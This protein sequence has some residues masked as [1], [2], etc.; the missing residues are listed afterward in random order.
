MFD[1]CVARDKFDDEDDEPSLLQG[2]PVVPQGQN[3]RL[4]IEEAR[5]SVPGVRRDKS[6]LFTRMR[7][8]QGRRRFEK[9]CSDIAEHA[10]SV[11]L[12]MIYAQVS[13]FHTS[14]ASQ[15]AQYSGLVRFSKDHCKSR[16]P[17]LEFVSAIPELTNSINE[18]FDKLEELLKETRD[19]GH[20]DDCP[21]DFATV[22]SALERHIDITRSRLRERFDKESETMLELKSSPFF[23]P[24]LTQKLGPK[25]AQMRERASSGSASPTTTPS[26]SLATSPNTTPCPPFRLPSAAAMASS[27]SDLRL[28]S[29]DGMLSDLESEDSD[30]D[31]A[32]GAKS[33]CPRVLPEGSAGGMASYK[34]D[35][36]KSNTSRIP[37]KGALGL[38]SLAGAQLQNNTRTSTPC[39]TAAKNS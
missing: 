34:D 27:V 30:D 22:R 5:L 11:K 13:E 29:L 32:T 2:E 4:P 31:A 8:L 38:S 17:P 9:P 24:K 1:V 10:G 7:E 20:G 36:A 25:L 3:P 15:L 18:R 28:K 19:L 39:S 35:K 14:L 16:V 12:A 37:F 33:S 6:M 21:S 26:S 23:S